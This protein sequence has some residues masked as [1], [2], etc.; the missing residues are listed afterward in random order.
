MASRNRPASGAMPP[1]RGGISGVGGRLPD[2]GEIGHEEG[3]RLLRSYVQDTL[4][5]KAVGD[6]AQYLGFVYDFVQLKQSDVQNSAESANKYAALLRAIGDSV[7]FLNESS[8]DRLCQELLSINLWTA[9]QVVAMAYAQLLV[10]LAISNQAFVPGVLK[11]LIRSFRPIHTAAEKG[12]SKPVRWHQ[13]QR[14][15]QVQDVVMVTL[16]KIIEFVPTCKA[17]VLK[18]F[19]SRRPNLWSSQSDHCLYLRALCDL[20]E[21]PAVVDMRESLLMKAVDH[22]M[23]IDV[24]IK[25]E[26]LLELPQGGNS[27]EDDSVFDLEAEDN[28]D[29]ATPSAV[30]N[31]SDLERSR[32]LMATM[33]CLMDIILRHLNKRCEAGQ[34]PLVWETMM[35]I[36]HQTLCHVHKSKFSQYIIFFLASRD[37]TRLCREFASHLLATIRSNAHPAAV[38]SSCAAYLASFMARAVLCPKELLVPCCEAL[39]EECER[40]MGEYD[41]KREQQTYVEAFLGTSGAEKVLQH[42]V[43]YSVAQAL[44]YVLCY[45][46]EPL[47]NSNSNERGSVQHLV[48]DK[49]RRILSHE[50]DPLSMCLKPVVQNFLHQ[51]SELGLGDFSCLRFQDVGGRGHRRL[52]TFFPFDPYLLRWSKGHLKLNESYRHWRGYK[53]DDSESCSESDDSSDSGSGS[54]Q[55]SDTDDDMIDASAP[56]HAAEPV[57]FRSRPV[58]VSAAD[59]RQDPIMGMSPLDYGISVSV[60]PA[61]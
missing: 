47:L 49:L 23:M 12:S 27:D 43:F 41:S 25:V 2:A 61:R 17:V 42:Q 1:A 45:H 46:L 34:L 8:H 13:S 36:F 58:P 51:A 11:W 5:S 9:P 56:S 30:Q 54:D 16:A 59:G 4:R 31:R 44:L 37:P 29:I 6:S 3:A 10:N 60:S 14:E 33:D 48:Q 35:Q 7:T 52:E 53:D 21:L 18:H 55:G 28:R 32:K 19:T 39:V 15:K 40:Y 24:E 50:L 57:P 26:D 20:A 38:R 22:L